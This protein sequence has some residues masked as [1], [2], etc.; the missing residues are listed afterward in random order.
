MSWPRHALGV[1]DWPRSI[2]RSIYQVTSRVCPQKLGAP[3]SMSKAKIVAPRRRV[4]LSIE[5]TTAAFIVLQIFLCTKSATAI[6]LSRFSAVVWHW[7][8]PVAQFALLNCSTVSQL[9]ALLSN[10]RALCRVQ[11]CW[12]LPTIRPTCSRNDYRSQ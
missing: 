4:G 12:S 3:K 1:P 9:L 8:A 5:F 2:D 11:D 10:S 6:G 7:R